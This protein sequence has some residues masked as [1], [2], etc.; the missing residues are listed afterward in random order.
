MDTNVFAESSGCPLYDEF[1][2][3]V[4][5]A[6]LLHRFTVRLS[7]SGRE[8]LEV[9]RLVPFLILD[10]FTE[11]L[12]HGPTLRQRSFFDIE[13][14]VPFISSSHAVGVV[15]SKTRLDAAV[16]HDMFKLIRGVRY[17]RTSYSC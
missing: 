16:K 15:P 2:G 3:Y 10:I 17:C 4:R 11:S 7:V 14:D 5:R 8:E 6:L 1:T 9:G 13:I 12:F